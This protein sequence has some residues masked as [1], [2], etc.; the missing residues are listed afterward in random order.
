MI[1]WLFSKRVRELEGALA[2]CQ[3]LLE[4][5]YKDVKL[6]RMHF[7]DGKFDVSCLHEGFAGL[8]AQWGY[9]TLKACDAE[10][11]VEIGVIHPTEGGLRITVQKERG[12]SPGSKAARLERE[13]DIQRGE[14]S[15]AVRLSPNTRPARAIAAVAGFTSLA[16]FPH[17]PALAIPLCLSAFGIW[18]GVLVERRYG[19]EFAAVWADAVLLS[20]LLTLSF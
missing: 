16:L 11:Y 9:N 20:P 8:I 10:N 1:A 5:R 17:W 15:L 19:T 3:A 13:L 18:C 6:V 14:T 4:G 7:E 2:H 12:E